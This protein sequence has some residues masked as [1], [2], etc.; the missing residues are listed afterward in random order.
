M[1]ILSNCPKCEQPVTVPDGVDPS[2][3]VRCPLCDAEYPLSEAMASAPPA[4]IPLDAVPADTEP[5][6]ETEPTDEG[7]VFGAWGQ[8][9]ESPEIEIGAQADATP[10]IDTGATAVDSEAF[11]GFSADEESTG[12]PQSLTTSMAKRRERGKQKSLAREIPKI[13]GGGLAGLIIGYYILNLWRGEEWDYLK[14]YLPFVEHTQNNWPMGGSEEDPAGDDAKKQSPQEKPGEQ[15]P[16]PAP[17]SPVDP[18]DELGDP[19]ELDDPMGSDLDDPMGS[20]LDDP[21]GSLP[22]VDSS[23]VPEPDIS[24]EPD[25]APKINVGPNDP[26]SFTSDELGEALKAADDAINGPGT[27]GEMTD[28]AYGHFCRLA[29]RITFAAAG[30]Q[31][32]DREMAVRGLLEDLAKRP[33]QLDRIGSLAAALW[34]AEEPAEGGVLLAGTVQKVGEKDGLRAIVVKLPQPYDKSL[35]LLKDKS[36]FIEEKDKV[37][38]IGSIVEDPKENVAGYAGSQKRVVWA[39]MAVVLPPE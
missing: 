10:A 5:A 29:H 2:G 6:T 3:Q 8:T 30:P 33:G 31:L 25:V 1:P 18:A 17:Q 35:L 34:D 12:E 16:K 26:P 37:L 9:D 28:E 32:G 23:L 21:I 36:L 14:V 20:D 39:G 11:A 13:I 7:P 4:L 22:P 27:G 38:A 19:S 24:F 15:K